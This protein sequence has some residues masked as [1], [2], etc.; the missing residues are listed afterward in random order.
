[1]NRSIAI[2]AGEPN[3]ISSEIIFKS[4]KNKNKYT[5]KPFFIIGSSELLKLQMKKLNY[6]I[7]IKK[8][9]NNFNDKDLSNN[10][11]AVYDVPYK[12]DRAFEK[13]SI[14]SNNY[15]FKCFQIALA[16]IKKKKIIGFVNLIMEYYLLL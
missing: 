7:Q 10:K 2:I 3:S 15:I 13:I 9:G 6:K 11:L 14:K 1:M 12:Q 8:I 5:H 16:L 4:W